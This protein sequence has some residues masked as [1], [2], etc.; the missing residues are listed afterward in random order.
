M[1]TRPR[2]LL[3]TKPDN[4]RGSIHGKITAYSEM[5]NF[6]EL[7]RHNNKNLEKEKAKFKI[8]NDILTPINSYVINELISLGCSDIRFYEEILTDE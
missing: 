6:I 1:K 2:Q 5:W 8:R 7:L 4:I 3:Y